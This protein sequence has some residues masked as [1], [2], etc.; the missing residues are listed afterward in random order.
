M[1]PIPRHLRLFDERRKTK[2]GPLMHVNPRQ[3]GADYIPT[4]AANLRMGGY[5]SELVPFA[6]SGGQVHFALDYRDSSTNPTVVYAVLE[7]GYD[8]PNAFRQI[9]PDVTTLLDRLEPE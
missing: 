4:A 9:A 3:G 5:P 2:F 7:F 1:V 8:D 6:G